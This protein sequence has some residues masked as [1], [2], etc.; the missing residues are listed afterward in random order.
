MPA[1]A[2]SES[3]EYFLSWAENVKTWPREVGGDAL[4]LSNAN[5][6]VTH[7]STYHFAQRDVF[8]LLSSRSM[9]WVHCLLNVMH[10]STWHQRP[11]WK[12]NHASETSDFLLNRLTSVWRPGLLL[13]IFT[14]LSSSSSRHSANALRPA[15][16][17]YSASGCSRAPPAWP[18]VTD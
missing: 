18:G 8:H 11:I 1:M 13:S 9:E 14:K 5:A 3:S 2:G 12:A 6:L 7:V 4:L 10:W 15:A 16:L 17:A